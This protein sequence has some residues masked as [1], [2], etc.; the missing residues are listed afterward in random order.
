MM[1][2]RPR[3]TVVGPLLMGLIVLLAFGALATTAPRTGN[4]AISELLTSNSRAI[5]S[6]SARS[7]FNPLYNLDTGSLQR[8]LNGL[9]GETNVVH[10]AVRDTNGQIVAQVTAE[11]EEGWVPEEQIGRGLGFQA[12][13][14]QEIIHREIEDYLVLCGPI[15]AGSEQIGTLI[16]AFDQAPL[17]TVNKYMRRLLLPLLV[18]VSAGSIL[19]V[20]AIAHLAAAS[21]LRA[22]TTAATEIGHGN[23]DTPMPIRGMAE[24]ATLGTALEHMRA[25]LQELY[26]G[27]EQQVA[28]LERRAQYLEATAGV[29]RDAAS[30]LDL[31]ELLSRVTTLI[32]ERLG[33]YHTGVFLLD[34]TGE[35]AVLQAASSEGGQR[36]LARGHRLRVGADN[37]DIG[38]ASADVGRASVRASEEG[39]V[40]YVT[41]K[42]EPRVALDVGADAVF[43]NNPDLPDTRSEM[44]LPLQARGEIIGA[45]DVQSAE[46]AAFNKEDV[47]VLQTLADQVAMAISNA[48]LFQQAQ[49]SLDAVQRAYGELSHEAWA[50]M[51]QGPSEVGY[52]CDDRGV[53]SLPEEADAPEDENLPSTRMPAL[54]I[55][56]AVRGGRTIGTVNAHKPGGANEW[57]TEEITLMKALIEQLGVAL[58]SARLYQD[59]QRR[60]FRE[61]LVG[62]VTAQVRKSLDLESVLRTAADEIHQALGLE[63]VVIHLATDE[64]SNDSA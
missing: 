32:S 20:A 9:L 40:G 64:A 56:I 28:S 42:G 26:L 14:Q 36:M 3:L 31:Q 38:R 7:L 35:W 17:D 51:L 46:A 49:E 33:F 61:R 15:A 47:T 57:T 43:F 24:T 62:E 59:T 5:F 44:A 34:P 10:A 21:P 1:R 54:S 41:D 55:P 12:L 63:E 22:L 39:V 48:Q 37:A 50:E 29:A 19:L 23:L 27:L 45:L 25:E 2:T 13:A 11:A 53:T 8:T 58:E 30:L 18:L 6:I 4:K 60:A 16:I 52:Y